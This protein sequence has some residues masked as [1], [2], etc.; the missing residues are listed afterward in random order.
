MS[1][2]A[3]IGAGGHAKVV[4]DVLRCSRTCV[5]WG[6]FDDDASL[7]GR[8]FCGI[9]VKGPV[10]ALASQ[11][12]PVDGVIVAIGDNATRQRIGRFVL[13]AGYALATAI[14]P[15]AIVA[16][17]ATIGAGTVLMAAVVIQPGA[18]LGQNVIVNTAATIDH[19]CVLGD[20]AHLAPGVHLAGSV[21]IGAR[22]MLGVGTVVIPNRLIGDDCL[23]GAGSVVVRDIPSRT[24]AFGAPAVARRL[25][26]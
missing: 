11:R 15:S 18:V 17:A 8:E 5:V 3:V 26:S 1:V 10:M 7:H 6:C 16:A 24:V 12:P 4:V 13:D 2:I 9:T 22:T 19:D 14:H 21:R 20:G 23:I 25:A